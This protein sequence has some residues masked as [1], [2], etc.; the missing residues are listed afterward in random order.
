MCLMVSAEEVKRMYFLKKLAELASPKSRIGR[1]I[2]AFDDIETYDSV[3]KKRLLV[4]RPVRTQENPS[5]Q[6]HKVH[7]YVDRYLVKS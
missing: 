2:D 3:M 6:V 7:T 5:E 4:K 1:V